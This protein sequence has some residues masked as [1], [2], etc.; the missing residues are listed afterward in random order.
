MKR[1]T[2]KKRHGSFRRII[3]AILSKFKKQEPE[4]YNGLTIKL[5]MAEDAK[6]NSDQYRKEYIIFMVDGKL[7]YFEQI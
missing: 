3:N 4:P 5:L 2:K 6:K 7:F 1:V